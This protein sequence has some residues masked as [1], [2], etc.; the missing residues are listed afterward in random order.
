[1][2]KEILMIKLSD[3]IKQLIEDGVS[4][5]DLDGCLQAIIKEALDYKE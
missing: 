3:R 5:K 1:M 2:K 4:G